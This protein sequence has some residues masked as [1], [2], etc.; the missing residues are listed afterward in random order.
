MVYGWLTYAKRSR[1]NP[2]ECEHNDPD[3]LDARL[4]PSVVLAV[5]PAVTMHEVSFLLTPAILCRRRSERIS[6][7]VNPAQRPRLPIQSTAIFGTR[8]GDFELFT[9]LD[10]SCWVSS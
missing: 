3:S 5:A 4:F 2:C 10:V 6:D 9:L 1:A 7:G 8:D